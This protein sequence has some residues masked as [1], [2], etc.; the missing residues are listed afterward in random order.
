MVPHV[1][2]NFRFGRCLKYIPVKNGKKII[3]PMILLIL[4]FHSNL[5]FSQ[6]TRNPLLEDVRTLAIRDAFG[7]L[8]YKD[9]DGS[10][11]YTDKFINGTVYLK[12]VVNDT[13]LHLRYDLFRIRLKL[14]RMEPSTGFLKTVS[15]L[16][17][18]EQKRSSRKPPLKIRV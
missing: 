4:Q 14:N 18:M 2:I 6:L 11:Y 17:G 16:S 15:L 8:T 5:L 7:V 9:I 3:M 13:S 10:P 1:N 12:D